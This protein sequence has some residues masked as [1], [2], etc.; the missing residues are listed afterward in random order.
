MVLKMELGQ[1]VGGGAI[2]VMQGSVK[3][4][5]GISRSSIPKN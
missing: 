2:A 4:Q 5:S 3:S 1:G